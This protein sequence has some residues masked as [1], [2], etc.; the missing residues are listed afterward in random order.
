MGSSWGFNLKKSSKRNSIPKNTIGEHIYFSLFGIQVI[1]AQAF[2]LMQ[3]K[4]LL[5]GEE[6]LQRPSVADI[7][8]GSDSWY[9]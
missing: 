6:V 3:V 9:N 7:C 1:D 5:R 4:C 2:H 8:F